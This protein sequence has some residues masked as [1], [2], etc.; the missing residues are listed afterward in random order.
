VDVVA[1]RNSEVE[2]DCSGAPLN[3]VDQDDDAAEPPEGDEG[4]SIAPEV[5]NTADEEEEAQQ[6]LGFV[7]PGMPTAAQVA[8]HNLT[9]IPARPWCDHC[10]R[11][12]G[13]DRH[14]R[15]LCGAYAESHVP[16]VRLDYCFLTENTEQLE[17][18]HGQG[19]TT[20]SSA[21]MTVLVMQESQCRSV[22]A[23]AV[24]SKGSSEAWVIDQISE[25]LDTIGFRNDRIIIKSDQETSANDIAREVAKRRAST[26]GTALENSAVGDS[27]SNGTV[28]RAIQ[29]VEGQCRTMRSALEE[30]LAVPVKLDSPVVPWLIRHA[31]VLITRCRVRPSGRT[32]F[33]LMKGRR[34]N[35]RLAEFGEIMHF[36]IPHTKLN[37]GKFEDAWADGVWLGV[38]LRSGENFIG[39]NVGVFRVA[40]VRRKPEDQRWSVARI[41]AITGCPRQPVPGQAARRSPAYSR[42]FELSKPTDETFVPQ[43]PAENRVRTWKIYQ[44]DVHAH[45]PT[46][47]C[48][49]CTAVMRG[50]T[51]KAGHTA[52]CR[53]RMQDLIMTDDVGRAR[54]ERAHDRIDQ[55]ANPPEAPRPGGGGGDAAP[56]ATPPPPMPPPSA[57]P[58]SPSAPPD[59]EPAR[60][61]RDPPPRAIPRILPRPIRPGE[62]VTPPVGSEAREQLI[63]RARQMRKRAADA[64]PDDPRTTNT[65]TPEVEPPRGSKR[66]A[67]FEPDD[68][69]LAAEGDES[70]VVTDMP[71]PSGQPESHRPANSIEH[72]CGSC[73]ESFPSRNALH[74][75]LRKRNHQVID[76]DD[77]P[78]GLLDSS[79]EEDNESDD[80]EVDA[81]M[82]DGDPS[83][84][85]E[86]GQTVR[87]RDIVGSAKA[88]RE[89]RTQSGHCR[90][91]RSV[92]LPKV[93]GGSTQRGTKPGVAVT[94]K[95]IRADILAHFGN[96]TL[97]PGSRA[98]IP[99]DSLAS[100]PGPVMRRKDIKSRDL[101]WT[102][103]GS[104][105][106]A[107]TFIGAERLVVTSRGGP[108]IGDIASR[109]IWS[110]STGKM[111][112]E[113][114]I[115]D[116]PDKILERKLPEPDDIRVELVLKGALDLYQRRGAD[117]CEIF[118]QPRVC[119]E[120]RHSGLQPGW[121][122]D[123]TTKDPANG[124]AWDLSD[125]KVQSRVKRLVNDTR[126]YCIIGS[127][128]CTAF[129]PLQEIG[130][131]KRDPKVMQMELDKGKAHIRFCL[132]IYAMQLRARR[133]F[134]HE[135]P[136]KSRAWHMPEVMQFLLR[137]EV[138]AVTL[139]MC[140]FGMKGKDELGEDLVQKATRIMSSS[141]EVL[142]QVNLQCT[143]RGGG[144]QH[145][146]VHLISG[147]A[148]Y[149]QV[150]PRLFSERLCEGIASQ[151]RLD[152]LGLTA[153]P[154]MSL[155]EMNSVAK[156]AS[157]AECPSSA[158]HEDTSGMIAIDDVSGQRLDPRLMVQARK[159]EI[160]YFRAMG[161]Y[162]KVD[163]SEAWSETGRA[164]IAVRWVDINK[165]DSAN[166]NYR[167][168]LVAKE[169]NTG[170]MPELYAATP[171]S[172]CLRLMLSMTASG[173]RQDIGLMYAD[174]SRAYFYAKAVRPVYVKLPAEDTESGDNGKCG[175]LKMSM[176]GTRDAAL[177]WSLEYAETL[178]AGGYVQGKSN[179]CLFHNSK[180]GVSVMVH[181]DDFVAVGPRK[182]L[183]ETRSTLESKY[184]LKVET[185]GN[186]KGDSSE[187]RILNKVVRATPVGIELEADPRHAELVVKELNLENAKPS[188]VPGS[189]ES[190]NSEIPKTST[191]TASRHTKARI[192][193]ESEVSSIESATKSAGEDQWDEPEEE[194]EV[195]DDESEE[196]LDAA[197]AKLYRSVAARLNYLSPDRADIGYAVKEAARNMSAPK[198]S[199]LRRLRKIGKYLLGRPR[200]VSLFKFQDM[201]S[202]ITAFTDSDWAGCTR[203]AKSTSGGA[204]CI[205][206]HVI[207]AY[208]KQ[209]K[210][211][212][213][214]SAEAELYAMVAASA[215]T[216]AL[217][218]YAKDLGLDFGC[219]LYCDSSAAL[220]IAQRAGI[221]KVRHLRTQGLWVQE[222]RV[223]GRIAY[224]KVLGEKNPADLLT[225]HMSADLANRHLECLNMK[226]SDGR[227]DTA[228]TLDSVVRAWY[229]GGNAKRGARVRF[230]DK[231]MY[232]GIPAEGKQRHTPPRG[233]DIRK[234]GDVDLSVVADDMN[235]Q[236]EHAAEQEVICSSGGAIRVGLVARG[237]RWA[238]AGNDFP[239]TH[240]CA[241]DAEDDYL[242]KPPARQHSQDLL[243]LEFLRGTEEATGESD[244]FEDWQVEEPEM[245]SGQK[246]L[247]SLPSSTT[248]CSGSDRIDAHSSV[249]IPFAH[250]SCIFVSAHSSDAV[251][252]DDG[253]FDVGDND[254]LN[255]DCLCDW[256]M[257]S[258]HGMRR[259]F[260]YKDSPLPLVMPTAHSIKLTQCRVVPGSF[261]VSRSLRN[262]R[263]RSAESWAHTDTS[264]HVFMH[265]WRWAPWH[266]CVYTRCVPSSLVA[267]AQVFIVFVNSNNTYT[268]PVPSRAC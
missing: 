139:H 109:R 28:E 116:V 50:S 129:S 102:D 215:E 12:K 169:F 248:K 113:C 153:R 212:A 95:S 226:V 224:K 138:G 121:S 171:P 123:L 48:A 182:H 225:K 135:H 91:S 133:H 90:E 118:S 159:E 199:D 132:E 111:L 71:V 52:E 3:P 49:G 249:C 101:Q 198:V 35:G 105:V 18:E 267:S 16:R 99:I 253:G 68:P 134:V 211:I 168:R 142:K 98:S 69:R 227:A 60:G 204:V 263:R 144:R 167:S 51:Y 89:S 115:D 34:S 268:S 1:I 175:K 25:D 250:S 161:V 256:G 239:R 174:V 201:P 119:Q 54:V 131:A 30:R 172:E 252:S 45:G 58:D 86:P 11:G 141:E 192:A 62:Q 47:G 125:P 4:T 23:Y 189:K 186:E 205:G 176:Y 72:E 235:Y 237:A 31:A 222:V 92:G 130:R 207:K 177:N 41:A 162:E 146:H 254:R 158:L 122:L 145:R 14:H 82:G 57:P 165:G 5:D 36:K 39:T 202:T 196:E 76:D 15:R 232:R 44:H 110:L 160:Q 203:S 155:E 151:K 59:S 258:V 74:C 126:P 261:S 184:K 187:L 257:S 33:E 108:C 26:F 223:A 190:S 96:S 234:P 216:L 29:D 67:E 213:L 137:P 43:P 103:V 219:E 150:Y 106:F 170:V 143:N 46:E 193:I 166:P 247:E 107:R 241:L 22:W 73:G 75:H 88:T 157:E 245:T 164:P 200:L 2:A 55:A 262:F 114:D 208:C 87:A 140:A 231:V 246:S 79:D 27:N 85:V 217:Q 112:D 127:P 70:E 117:V 233:S 260:I 37:P 173:K 240:S 230:S 214:S 197:G 147:R 179:P 220:G 181:G 38:D 120:A 19:Q 221:G 178:R 83:G 6:P 191:A 154:I 185:L 93:I 180:L 266:V 128:P 238:D 61:S 255:T 13:K 97:A 20:Q 156:D 42:K 56:Q 17:D 206:E 66:Q 236:E 209:Q 104:G 264:A 63:A 242:R 228:P 8:E 210:V 188:S 251:H 229:E 21:S 10:M 152:Q 265:S 80:D 194:I 243:S 9:H 259:E 40:T 32:S 77:S 81:T 94:P 64:P 124:K 136:D 53:R 65:D 100:H 148:K 7:D 218:A 195:K 163:I 149:A 78:P 183:V 244:N 84:R 24:E